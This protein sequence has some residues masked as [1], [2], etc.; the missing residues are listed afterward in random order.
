MAEQTNKKITIEYREVGDDKM[1][2]VDRRKLAAAFNKDYST[3][4]RWEDDGLPVYHQGDNPNSPKIFK[5]SDCVTWYMNRETQPYLTE[6]ESMRRNLNQGKSAKDRKIEG[7]AVLVELDAV[8]RLR[9]VGKIKDIAD[10][11]NTA[12]D[13]IRSKLVGFAGKKAET[14]VGLEHFEIEQ[15]LSDGINEILNEIHTF[16]VDEMRRCFENGRS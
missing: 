5:I 1:V 4:R 10:V 15:E 3:I 16:N 2:L 12:L 11:F 8:E 6:I 9:M 14:L 7:E 13:T